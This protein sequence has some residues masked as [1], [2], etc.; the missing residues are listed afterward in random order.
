MSYVL[1]RQRSSD[2]LHR[3]RSRS[4]APA[5]LTIVAVVTTVGV[6]VGSVSP[7]E[8][9][10]TCAAALNLTG[11]CLMQGRW[12]LS[13]SQAV[14][15]QRESTELFRAELHAFVDQ[16]TV[17]LAQ[18]QQ[19]CDARI[20]QLK[21][22]MDQRAAAD[23]VRASSGREDYDKTMK[24]IAKDTND[25]AHHTLDNVKL[26]VKSQLKADQELLRGPPWVSG[27]SARVPC[28]SRS[29]SWHAD[30]LG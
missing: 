9:G 29:C 11:T 22:H 30:S 21:A 10:T 8:H 14:Q 23:Q 6:T 19:Q 1:A 4:L 24:I 27:T 17:L 3:G 7:R 28:S 13:I 16:Q 15:G 20:H 25:Y 18:A 12:L 5:L 26:L 2:V